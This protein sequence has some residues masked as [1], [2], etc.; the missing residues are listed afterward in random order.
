MHSFYPLRV[1]I[2]RLSPSHCSYIMAS[3]SGTSHIIDLP[4]P[5]VD[6]ATAACRQLQCIGHHYYNSSPLLQ[7]TSSHHYYNAPTTTAY[8]PP[9]TTYHQHYYYIPAVTTPVPSTTTAYNFQS[10]TQRTVPRQQLWLCTTHRIKTDH[11]SGL[12]YL[13]TNTARCTGVTAT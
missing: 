13:V 11:Q 7:R 4:N 8:Q 3:A 2:T 5:N 10:P 9:T 12:H 6:L 1:P